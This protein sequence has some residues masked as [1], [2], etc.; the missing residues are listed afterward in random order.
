MSSLVSKFASYLSTVWREGRKRERERERQT[1]DL[2]E[3]VR[4]HARGSPF[5]CPPRKRAT[6]GKESQSAWA[7]GVQIIGESSV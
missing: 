6:L 5:M 1:A 3:R 4:T 7:C 2:Q